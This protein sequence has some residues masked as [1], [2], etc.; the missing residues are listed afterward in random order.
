[1]DREATIATVQPRASRQANSASRGRGKKPPAL[2]RSQHAEDCRFYEAI[3]Y[4]P[5][6]T[7]EEAALWARRSNLAD[8]ADYAN[9]PTWAA[10]ECNRRVLE[11]LTEFPALRGKLEFLG[12]NLAWARM[13]RA[14]AQSAKA[15]SLAAQDPQRPAAQTERE[16]RE[17]SLKV[18]RR[19]WGHACHYAGLAFRWPLSGISVKYRGTVGPSTVACLRRTVDHELGHLLDRMFAIHRVPIIRRL[20][21]EWPYE[22]VAREL[23]EYAK[24][25]ESEFVAVAWASFR[26]DAQ[27]GSLARTV[28]LEVVEQYDRR[29]VA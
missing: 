18:F 29:F 6:A 11:A 2:A 26:N 28:G 8:A 24:K 10:N 19:D 15:R 4:E 14:H 17:E 5:A 25:S 7:A 3:R 21:F 20:A 22:D 9:L 16:A 13:N 23:G 27:P 12:S 1:M